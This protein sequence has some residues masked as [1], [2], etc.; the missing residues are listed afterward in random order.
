DVDVVGIGIG[1]G[2]IGIDDVVVVERRRIRI[3]CV[4]GVVQR[5][6]I[7]RVRAGRVIRLGR[8]VV[9]TSGIGGVRRVRIV[10]LHIVSS[11]VRIVCVG[12]RLVVGSKIAAFPVPVFRP[13]DPAHA[14]SAL[15]L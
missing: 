2:G 13:S 3:G 4:V 9:G 5:L 8:C 10:R 1:I 7:R 6:V 12:R 15:E 14:A 11:I